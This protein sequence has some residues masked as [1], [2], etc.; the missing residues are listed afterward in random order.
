MR[1][2][3]DG[4]KSRIKI[5]LPVVLAKQEPCLPR[6]TI[7][8]GPPACLES[9]TEVS[10]RT[11]GYREAQEKEK[12]QMAVEHHAFIEAEKRV[13]SFLKGNGED[14]A[15]LDENEILKVTGL[16]ESAKNLARNIVSS[17]RKSPNGSVG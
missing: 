11:R 17:P 15:G 8:S 9:Y 10:M 7:F 5:I 1:R 2:Q 4:L 3:L 6:R 12:Q 13:A 16:L 14:A